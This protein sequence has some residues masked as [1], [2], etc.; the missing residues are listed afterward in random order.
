M[1]IQLYMGQLSGCEICTEMAWLCFYGK[2]ARTAV[3]ARGLLLMVISS[4]T[5]NI[6]PKIFK[7]PKSPNINVR[8]YQA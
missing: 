5:G 6:A 3:E 4:D 1:T 7:N 2:W 8:N